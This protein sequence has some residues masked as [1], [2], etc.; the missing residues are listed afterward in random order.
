[1]EMRLSVDQVG[2]SVDNLQLQIE[3]PIPMK[4]RADNVRDFVLFTGPT[5]HTKK[6]QKYR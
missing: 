6:I 5:L 1:M 3:I 4:I 2:F